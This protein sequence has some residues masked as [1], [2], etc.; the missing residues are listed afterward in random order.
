MASEE[1][2]KLALANG[3]PITIPPPTFVARRSPLPWR[4]ER[5]LWRN[6]DPAD[7]DVDRGAVA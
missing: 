5:P 3:P 4:V 6:L 1:L 2:A 7:D